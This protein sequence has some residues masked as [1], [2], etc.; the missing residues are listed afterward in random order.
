M[1]SYFTGFVATPTQHGQTI[2]HTLLKEVANKKN[3]GDLTQ[4]KCVCSLDAYAD[5][6][7]SEML[8]MIATREF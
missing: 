7:I 8:I 4:L 6:L 1:N 3:V 2:V 5:N